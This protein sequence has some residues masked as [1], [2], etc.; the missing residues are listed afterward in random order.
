MRNAILT[1]ALTFVAGILNG[2][3]VLIGKVV[4]ATSNLPIG[5]ASVY[6]NNTSV[7]TITNN[8]GGFVLNM[9]SIYTG[10]L[11]V[12]SVGYQPLSYQL[13][14]KDADKKF[15][16]F[17]LELKEKTLSSILIVSD[18]TRQAWLKIFKENFL[19]LTEEA[20]NCKI[21]NLQAVYFTTGEKKNTIY[22]YTDTPLIITNKLLGYKIA[23]DLVEF[24][25]DKNNAST[26]FLGYS[27][28][29]ETGYKKRWVK[30]RKQNY[31]GSTMH[32]YRSLVANQLAA[33]GFSIFEIIPI[34]LHI[35]SVTTKMNI[36]I[37]GNN[38]AMA[39][40]LQASKIVFADSVPNYYYLKTAN[41]IMVQYNKTP[42]TK[43]YLAKKFFL[44][45]I[46]HN[47]FTAYIT[48]LASEVKMDK[49]GVIYN[50]LSV[51]Y[52]GFWMYEKLANQ[53]PFNY[54]PN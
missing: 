32:F 3:I 12:S 10:E 22:A 44:Q 5:N 31:F 41:K 38:P 47:G 45:G 33:N 29:A 53:L 20:D 6:L 21:E 11:I 14:S 4:N 25:F 1:F 8:E 37:T 52:S 42:Y 19:G 40:P 26:Y 2:Q 36:K 17:K 54:Y 35:D 16:T 39:V 9:A 51:M 13:N 43:D 7:G 18:A 49:D 28:Y 15:Y 48:L 23:F 46:S 30:R 50:P 24:S 27:R 34:K